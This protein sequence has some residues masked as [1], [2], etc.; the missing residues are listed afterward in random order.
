[1]F[2]LVKFVLLMVAS[3]LLW[4]CTASAPAAELPVVEPPVILP[5]SVEAE[6]SLPTPGIPTPTVTES[7]PTNPFDILGTGDEMESV[8]DISVKFFERVP[9]GALALSA[10]H[11]SVTDAFI[12]EST[13]SGILYDTETRAVTAASP[14]SS[15]D[16]RTNQFFVAP[17][18]SLVAIKIS[19][20]DDDGNLFGCASNMDMWARIGDGPY[21]K[22]AINP[23]MVEKQT[24]AYPFFAATGWGRACTAEGWLYGFYP[25]TGYD[26]AALRVVLNRV[27]FSR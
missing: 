19:L 7:A 17:G 12:V 26:P 14:E 5:T 16:W 3:V 9:L 2:K 23:N 20:Y 4:A 24:G 6:A 18:V 27:E 21:V 8:F 10:T 11:F 13:G 25:G 1:M 15:R 22:G